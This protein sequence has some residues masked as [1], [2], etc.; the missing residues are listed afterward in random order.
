MVLYVILCYKATEQRDVDANPGD[1]FVKVVGPPSES[2]HYSFTWK[3][4]GNGRRLEYRGPC[5]PLHL[6]LEELHEKG[7][8][9][10]TQLGRSKRRV[11]ASDSTQTALFGS[12][13]TEK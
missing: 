12:V 4:Q 1:F 2:A 5:A 8:S 10:R 11:A 7:L 9:I 6:S 3:I 13:N